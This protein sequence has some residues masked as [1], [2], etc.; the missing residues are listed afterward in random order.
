ML[1]LKNFL[2]HNIWLKSVFLKLE[3][4]KITLLSYYKQTDVLFAEEKYSSLCNLCADSN[5]KCSSED[6]FA[7]YSGALSCLLDGGDIAW[8]KYSEIEEFFEDKEQ[9]R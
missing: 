2:Y 3:W 6:A 7:G 9:V 1:L 4:L 8:S 5:K